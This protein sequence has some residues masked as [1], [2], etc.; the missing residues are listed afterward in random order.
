[1]GVRSRSKSITLPRAGGGG[2]GGGGGGADLISELSDDLL[3]R[4]L[5]VLPDARDAVRT[6]ALSRR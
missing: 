4:V 3:V 1:M 6:H 5:E 2:G